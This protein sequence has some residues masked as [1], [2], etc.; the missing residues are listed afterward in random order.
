VT[1]YHEFSLTLVTE[2]K[3]D[4]K[5]LQDLFDKAIDLFCNCN[6]NG[7]DCR[8]AAGS[9]NINLTEEEFNKLYND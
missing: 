7:E 9:T 5:E 4:M 8:L 3:E 1:Y 6:G 2:E